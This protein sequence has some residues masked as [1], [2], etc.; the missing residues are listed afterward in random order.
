MSKA[1]NN[2]IAGNVGAA[3]AAFLNKGGCA[4]SSFAFITFVTPS[5]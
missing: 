1:K 4:P 5:P 3:S 2:L